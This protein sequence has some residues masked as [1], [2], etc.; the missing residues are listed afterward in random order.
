MTCKMTF[1]TEVFFLTHGKD[2]Y[3][4]RPYHREMYDVSYA[5]YKQTDNGF[6]KVC[7]FDCNT[8]D[9]PEEVFAAMMFCVDLANDF[10]DDWKWKEAEEAW[11]ERF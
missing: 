3:M 2:T 10:G 4:L 1:G 8:D 7:C 9:Y 6:E 5:A 11:K